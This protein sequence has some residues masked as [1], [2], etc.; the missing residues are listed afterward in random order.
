[1]HAS[2]HDERVLVRLPLRQSWQWPA[3]GQ[4]PPA[5]LP[6]S[7]RLPRYELSLADDGG[8]IRALDEKALEQARQVV[9]STFGPALDFGTPRVHAYTEQGVL[10]E[11][12]MFVKVNARRAHLQWLVDE[13]RGRGARMQ[14]VE[15]QRQRVIVR[16]EAW[17]AALLGFEQAVLAATTHSAQVSTW[18]VRYER[19]TAPGVRPSRAGPD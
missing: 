9:T 7:S 5:S 10:L 8:E 2:A 18:L 1:M 19:T 13:L 12:L 16:A 11:P 3:A 15:L 6:L 14:E 17:L 4:P